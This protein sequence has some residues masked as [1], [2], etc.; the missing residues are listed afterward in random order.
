MISVEFGLSDMFNAVSSFNHFAH[1][2]GHEGLCLVGSLLHFLVAHLHR[3]IEATEVGDDADTEGAY[4]AV[5][6]YDDF[7]N[8]GHAYGIAAYHA[9]H[10]ILCGG[11]E[12]RTL[13]THVD[14]VGEADLLLL[15]NGGSLLDERQ[16]VGL[17][18]VGEARSGGEV[19]A[20]Q[21]VLGEH[22][23]V[24][25]DNHQVANLEG[26]VHTAGGIR[27]EEGLD[28]QFV[29]DAHGEGD[30]LHG[31]ALVVVEA[32]LHGQDVYPAKFAEYQFATM[33]F[34]GRY[35]EVGNVGI[36]NLVLFS[37]F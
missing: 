13:D 24:V 28:A 26:R 14:T 32:A 35:R 17:V 33:T 1:N 20:A 8:G 36:G 29:H 15:G 6:G 31:V 34:H 2:L 12:R 16:V 37:N 21:R 11:L 9:V 4:A 10:L 23:D 3:S 7:G 27:H 30:F 18:H 25:G 19:L 5:V 22:V